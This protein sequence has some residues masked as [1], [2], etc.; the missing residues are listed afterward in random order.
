[1]K[2]TVAPKGV[3][4]AVVGALVGELVGAVDGALVGEAVG[5]GVVG[6]AVGPGVVGVAVVGAAVS[7]LRPGSSRLAFPVGLRC[8]VPNTIDPMCNAERGIFGVTART[9]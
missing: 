9:D 7:S 3:V 4:G 8:V 6:V 1:M 2:Y 5:P